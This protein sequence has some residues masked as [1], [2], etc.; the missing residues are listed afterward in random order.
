M[1]VPTDQNFDTISGTLGTGFAT[2]NGVTYFNTDP[3]A[4]LT[5][6][7]SRLS[8][9]AS[10]LAQTVAGFKTADGSEFQLNSLDL[11]NAA[12][13]E[14]DGYRDGVLVAALGFTIPGAGKLAFSG[15]DNIDEFRLTRS[16]SGPIVIDT[17]D[18][19]AP[20]VSHL[21]PTITGLLGDAQSY[22]EGGQP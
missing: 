3:A 14:I 12:T 13:Y 22:T 15:F 17:L 10:N 18:F 20:I 9:G 5:V 11:Y 1:T 7:D 21:A 6:S 8:L 2:I 16:D 19:S 4:V